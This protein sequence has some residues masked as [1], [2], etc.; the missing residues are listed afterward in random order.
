MNAKLQ[1]AES[2]IESYKKI[3]SNYQNKISE[4]KIKCIADN[5][6]DSVSGENKNKLIINN[7]QQ[8]LPIIN[9]TNRYNLLFKSNLHLHLTNF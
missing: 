4:M 6:G 2:E 3:I 9:N 8:Q 5:N 1:V 7:T